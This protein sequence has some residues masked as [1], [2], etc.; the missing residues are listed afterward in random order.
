M[1]IAAVIPA[2]SGSQRVVDKNIAC[3]AGAPL[4]GI[5]AMQA[6]KVPQIDSIFPITDSEH[7]MDIFSDYGLNRFTL[8]PHHTALSESP[9]ITWL[10]WW[11]SEVGHSTFDAVV[12]LR[13]TS[14]LR[15]RATIIDGI[16]LLK[17]NWSRVDSVRCVSPVTEHPGKMWI[18]QG[19]I[20]NPL[21]PF[22]NDQAP[23]HSSQMKTLPQVY[24]QNAMLEVVKIQSV[25]RNNTISG[26]V[27]MPLVRE[28]YE[29]LDVNQQIDLDF[30]KFIVSQNP[31]LVDW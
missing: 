28:G 9:D 3:V 16:S 4:I 12:I 21:L 6:Q 19:D 8:R 25:T 2:R 17:Q 18:P 15:R 14:P 7:Y 5:A 27:I 20:M 30:L 24:V 26:S 11:I 1:K 29:T 23:W 13:P 22:S 10:D 31:S